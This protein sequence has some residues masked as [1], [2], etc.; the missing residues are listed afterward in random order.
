MYSFRSTGKR[1]ALH[2]MV[3]GSIV[4]AG[5]LFSLS[6]MDGMSF[7]VIFQ[8]AA[9]ICLTVGVY[10][11]SRYSLRVYDYAIQPSGIVDAEGVEQYD[12]V[13]T[14]ITGKKM[15]VVTRLSLRDI[16]RPAVTVLPQSQKPDEGLTTSPEGKRQVFRYANTPV[17]SEACYI[18][19][20]S[21]PALVVIPVDDTMVK[22][23]RGRS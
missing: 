1:T 6:M 16:D 10:L 20:L 11:L 19:V 22:I 8:A 7:P 2:V 15:V 21:H 14:E 3:I 9:I 12:L 23:L 17:L 13:I 4:A 18:P 5:L